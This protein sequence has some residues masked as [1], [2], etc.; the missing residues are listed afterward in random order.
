MK[1]TEYMRLRTQEV[2]WLSLTV[3]HILIQLKNRT[4]QAETKSIIS[5]Q[6]NNISKLANAATLKINKIITMQN[7]TTIGIKLTEILIYEY[8]I[9]KT[10]TKTKTKTKVMWIQTQLLI[11]VVINHKVRIK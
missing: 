10:K 4:M 5:K 1:L 6:T 8:Q 7:L 9:I 2:L 3:R 11:Y